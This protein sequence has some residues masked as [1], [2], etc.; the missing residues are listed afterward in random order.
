MIIISLNTIAGVNYRHYVIIIIITST[1]SKLICFGYVCNRDVTIL[2]F[3][4]AAFMV[5]IFYVRWWILDQ[6]LHW[7]L[8][9]RDIIWDITQSAWW[10]RPIITPATAFNYFNI[11]PALIVHLL[12]SLGSIL[13]RRHF[14]GTHT[15]SSTDK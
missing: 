11:S 9:M 10:V 5:E 8:F 12:N 3:G 13:A 15:K 7:D 1:S 2:Q 14:R 4:Y 6:S